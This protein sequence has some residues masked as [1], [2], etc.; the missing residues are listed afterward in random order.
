MAKGKFMANKE[1]NSL[2][3][4]AEYYYKKNWIYATEL[5]EKA[6]RKDPSYIESYIKLAFFCLQKGLYQRA[7]KV[8]RQ[9]LV[10]SPENPELL[11]QMG[12]TFLSQK[13]KESEALYYYN[14]IKDKTLE[15][16]YNMSLAFARLG[17]YQNA[18][19][20]LTEIIKNN[21]NVIFPYHILAEQYIS[22]K[23]Y[24]NAI[25][26]LNIAEKRFPLEKRTYYLKG[27]ASYSKNEFLRAYLDFKRAEE[28][29]YIDANF[30]RLYGL[31]QER[32][33]NTKSAVKYLKKSID[34]DT[35]FI[36]AYIDLSKIYLKYN[37][38]E[39]AKKYIKLA[40]EIEPF[41]LYLSMMYARINQVLQKREKK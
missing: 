7:E 15:V 41:N 33:G 13:R 1:I 24:N 8:L 38:L 17:D 10:Y 2:I 26:V 27:L 16:K 25:S 22:I 31:C 34:T 4:Q 32:I 9:G 20:Y 29:G 40:R 14:K 28:L 18:I 35:M 23:E 37:Q 36:D 21:P 3:W 11:F 19:H 6:V 12:N 30:Y 39:M 5:L